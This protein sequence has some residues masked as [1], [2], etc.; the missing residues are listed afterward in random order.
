MIT[1]LEGV[2]GV[3]KSTHAAWLAKQQNARI[4][5]ASV[6]THPHWFEEYIKPLVDIPEGENVILDRWHLGE[7][8]WPFVFNRK[9]IFTR[10]ESLKLCH[11]TLLHMFGA[12]MILIYRDPDSITSTLMLRGEQDQ[13]ETV[14]KAQEMYFDLVATLDNIEVINSNYLQRELPRVY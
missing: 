9:S 13:I 10:P 4:I 8:I 5:H 6:P 11:S 1:I 14:I 12:K 2:D 7:A 3:G